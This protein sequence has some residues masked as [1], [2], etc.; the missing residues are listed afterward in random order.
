MP[1]DLHL[2]RPEEIEPRY[3]WGDPF[4]REALDHGEILHG[5]RPDHPTSSHRNWTTD[6]GHVKLSAALAYLDPDAGHP[7]PS[8]DVAWAIA[9]AGPLRECLRRWFDSLEA[10][11]PQEVA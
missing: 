11:E 9:H 3:R 8:Q 7:E 2:R 6:G 5:E 1:L 4:I 10:T